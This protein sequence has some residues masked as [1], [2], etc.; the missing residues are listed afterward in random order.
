MKKYFF[1]AGIPRSG[2]TLLSSILNQNPDIMVSANSFLCDQ[3]C[4]TVRIK[5][6]DVYRNFP[7]E[8]SLDNLVASTFDSYYKDWDAKYIID[9]GPWGTPP[10]LY[11]LENYLSNDI[12][13]ICT[14]RDIVEVI[15]SFIRLNPQALQQFLQ[16]QRERNLRF[17]DSYKEDIELMCE[18]VMDPSG[19]VEKNL[20]SLVN[21]LK[22]ENRKYL[23]IVEYND[24]VDDTDNTIKKIYDFLEIEHYPHKYNY[25][26]TFSANG[27]EY[28][29]S[30]YSADLHKLKKKIK[31]K[32]YKVED[33]LPP[34][35]IERYS[36]MEF[37][38]NEN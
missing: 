18:A 10:N 15:A 38:R 21:L 9:R 34:Y 22:E 24:L 28:D 30:V 5:F 4:A 13:I 6:S 32:N 12:K 35:L 1:L 2:N 8:K 19:Q 20:F 31:P 29:D 3:M 33:I 25:I 26:N 17:L 11:L 23:H 36:N 7:D 27:I 16:N 37:W 14:V